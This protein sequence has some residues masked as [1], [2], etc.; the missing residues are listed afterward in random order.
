[1]GDTDDLQM[2]FLLQYWDCNHSDSVFWPLLALQ[3][4]QHNAI[5]SR[6]IIDASLIICSQLAAV[7]LHIC[8]G[9]NSTP[10]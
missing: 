3:P 5:L 4:Q 10:Q 6:L 1:M 8:T 9:V 2:L 7:F